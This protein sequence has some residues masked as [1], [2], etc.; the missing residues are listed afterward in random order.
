MQCIAKGLQILGALSL[1]VI[2][3]AVGVLGYSVA[4]NGNRINVATK[5]GVQFV[6]NWSGLK[7]NQ[8]TKCLVAL[9]R[10]AH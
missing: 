5:D 8:D 9:S 2:L 4:T 7:S 3:V 10:R 6:F 1:A